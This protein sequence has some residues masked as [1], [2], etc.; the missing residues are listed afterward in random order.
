MIGKFYLL[1]I[2]LIELY[3]L[4]FPTLPLTLYLPSV[5]TLIPF[6]FRI[7]LPRIIAVTEVYKY[8]LLNPLGVYI[9]FK[10]PNNTLC[11][12]FSVHL[13]EDTSVISH[14]FYCENA[15]VFMR[16][17]SLLSDMDS[18]L[19]AVLPTHVRNTTLSTIIAILS[20]IFTNRKPP[21]MEYWICSIY[22]GVIQ[23]PALISMVYG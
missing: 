15:M 2:M 10:N 22:L 11:M 14:L 21:Q 12:T 20:D 19:L 23:N 17:V 1:K 6:R 18:F 8:N 4:H 5:T 13:F 3:L 9:V 16:M 7:S